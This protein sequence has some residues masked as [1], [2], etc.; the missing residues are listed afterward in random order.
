MPAQC[1]V[2]SLRNCC[3][4]L[5]LWKKLQFGSW[6]FNGR[7]V[8]LQPGTFDMSDFIENGEWAIL[9]ETV[10]L[11]IPIFFCHGSFSE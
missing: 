10:V 11:L 7:E 4:K 8:D 9:S 6:T 1:F 2:I 3:S 5:Y